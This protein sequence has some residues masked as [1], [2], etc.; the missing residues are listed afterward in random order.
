[1]FRVSL[2]RPSKDEIDAIATARSAGREGGSHEGVLTSLLNEMDGVEDLTGVTVIGATNRPDIIVR[3]A[4]SC[5][6]YRQTY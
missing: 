3:D 2:T 6:L 5:M 4:V 1:M